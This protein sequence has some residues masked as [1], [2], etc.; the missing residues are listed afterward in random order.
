MRIGLTLT[1]VPY[2][3]VEIP[4]NLLLKKIGPRL[5]LPTM[6]VSWGLVAALQNQVKSYGGFVA[7]RLILGFC[8]GEITILIFLPIL[9]LTCVEAGCIL[10]WYF[11]C[12]ASTAA[13]T[14]NFV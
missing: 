4:S 11:T 7:V 6:V 3:L 14:F 5:L 2:M 1:Y 10:E 13:R 9:G 8:E 12:P